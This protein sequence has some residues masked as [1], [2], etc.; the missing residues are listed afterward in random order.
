MK[1]MEQVARYVDRRVADA[2]RLPVEIGRRKSGRSGRAGV[3]PHRS[4]VGGPRPSG[5]LDLLPTVTADG[6]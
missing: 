4:S 2:E 1:Q 5:R 6:A 3:S